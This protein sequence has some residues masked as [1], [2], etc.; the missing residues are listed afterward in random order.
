MSKKYN[1]ICAYCQKPFVANSPS[2]KYCSNG[3]KNMAYKIRNNIPLPDFENTK[4]LNR[5]QSKTELALTDRIKMLQNLQEDCSNILNNYSDDVLKE[6]NEIEKEKITIS[7]KSAHYFRYS[8]AGTHKVNIKD[9]YKKFNIFCY[10][11]FMKYRYEEKDKLLKNVR[12]LYLQEYDNLK[13]KVINEYTNKQK[14]RADYIAKQEEIFNLKE[15]IESLQNGYDL[16]QLQYSNK[17]IKADDFANIEFDLYKL[18]DD[19][20]KV[21]G[22]PCKYFIAMLHGAK[23]SFKSSFALKFASYFAKKFGEVCYLSIEEGLSPSFQNKIKRYTEGNIYI[24]EERLPSKIKNNISSQYDLIIIDSVSQGNFDLKDIEQIISKRKQNNTS[25]LLIFQQT[26]D[27]DYKGGA[28][29][30]HLVDIVLKAENGIIKVDGKN[31]Y[32]LPDI[33]VQEY[34]M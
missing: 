17:I 34:S 29:F 18:D 13:Y 14:L 9:I 6:L 20:E 21:F 15:E 32:M 2:A 4:F 30:G 12:S 1:K 31:R 24:S 3:H 7:K 22:H 25:F 16:E 33:N 28:E 8:E 5:I 10:S 11:D 26:K 23:G 19:F 27:G